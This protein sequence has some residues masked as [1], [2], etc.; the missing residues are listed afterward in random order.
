MRPFNLERALAGDKVVTRD[1][2][3]V[4][5]V[6][7]LEIYISRPVIF[8][9]KG[10]DDVFQCNLNGVHNTGIID[11]HY[12]DLFMADSEPKAATYLVNVYKLPDGSL[13]NGQA[14]KSK[15]TPMV[16]MGYFLAGATLLKT[17][18]FTVE[19]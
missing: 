19:E 13:I 1:G 3:E 5:K 7:L 10:M 8:L 12:F 14:H 9:L 2:L 11:G 6:I 16:E 15:V 18:S 4:L 17:I